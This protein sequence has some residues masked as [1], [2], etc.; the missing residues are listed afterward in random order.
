MNPLQQMELARLDHQDR[1]QATQRNQPA[2]QLNWK[3]LFAFA[4]FEH[5]QVSADKVKPVNMKCD[6]VAVN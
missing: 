1:L 6:T 2:S 4:R 3:A 5:K